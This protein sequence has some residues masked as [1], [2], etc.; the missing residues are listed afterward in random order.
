MNT[1]ST[2]SDTPIYTVTASTVQSQATEQIGRKLTDN[3]LGD[4]GRSLEKGIDVQ[5]YLDE[6]ITFIDSPKN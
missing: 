1:N 5:F 4:V 2:K 3:E 6:A